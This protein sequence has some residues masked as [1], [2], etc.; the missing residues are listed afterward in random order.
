MLIALTYQ[1]TGESY[2]SMVMKFGGWY[3][4]YTYPI[5]YFINSLYRKYYHLI[6]GNSLHLWT[7][8]ID[9]FREAIWRQIVYNGDGVRDLE[10][11]LDNFR[12]FSF[13]DTIGHE[14]CSPGAGPFD[15]SNG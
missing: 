12:V 10:I 11:S 4:R 1:S 13:L 3:N 8:Q 5:H 6:S 9:T 15:F 2:S 14:T 7:A